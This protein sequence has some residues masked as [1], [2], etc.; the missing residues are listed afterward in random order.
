MS[1]CP[2]CGTKL[3]DGAR[4]CGECGLKLEGLFDEQIEPE[5]EI[6]PWELEAE[7]TKE[8]EPKNETMPWEKE[9][10]LP[11]EQDEKMPWEESEDAGAEED[12][13]SQLVKEI[14]ESTE[15]EAVEEVVTV[16]EIQPE[17]PK[18][19]EPVLE[20]PVPEAS[21]PEEPE[22]EV[23]KTPLR[24]SQLKKM[25]EQEQKSGQ[26]T[27]KKPNL[28]VKAYKEKAKSLSK[29][30]IIVLAEALILVV[31][32]GIFCAIGSSKG[33]PSSVAN[34]YVS[35]FTKGDW[36]TLYELTDLPESDFLTKEQFVKMKQSAESWGNSTFEVME[37]PWGTSEIERH[38]LVNCTVPGKGTTSFELNVVKQSEKTMLFFDSW[39]VSEV[40]IIAEN[41]PIYVP[42][43]AKVSIDGYLLN[44]SD[45][46]MDDDDR[47]D[48]YQVTMFTGNHT[49]QISQ[50]WCELYEEEFTM[51]SGDSYYAYAFNLTE[52]G[53]QTIQAMLQDTL[54]RC[55]QSAVTKKDFSEIEDL[56]LPETVSDCESAYKNLVEDLHGSSRYV[57]N[58]V[59]FSNF[60][61]EC[62]IEGGYFEATM[63]YNYFMNY[64]YIS[65]Y[66]GEASSRTDDGNSSISASFVFDGETYKISSL[67]IRSVL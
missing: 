27:I 21:N 64:T 66:S 45:M 33:S 16:Q 56:F 38:Y 11:W 60:R 40:G 26:I 12:P 39:K 50:P 65:S 1:F 4:F 2:E 31:V 15:K 52:E 18:A 25:R 29:Q 49:I 34:E 43:G 44:D 61:T 32:I 63:Q 46:I 47:T 5:A 51:W 28:D 59:T 22:Q 36:D 53:K 35:A 48:Q 37:Q 67:S 7:E 8:E 13:W 57:L 3:E 55:Y 6:M 42:A 17:E 19:E 23:T 30:Q 9:G 54:E 24:P 41:Y 14:A 20:D 58:S 10:K 62:Y